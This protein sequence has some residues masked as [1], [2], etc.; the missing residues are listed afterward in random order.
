MENLICNAYTVLEFNFSFEKYLND[1]RDMLDEEEH[2]ENWNVCLEAY[3]T[4]S[5][6]MT[7]DAIKQ[8]QALVMGEF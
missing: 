3:E 2:E 6:Y 4:V 5:Q 7:D 8:A 1:N